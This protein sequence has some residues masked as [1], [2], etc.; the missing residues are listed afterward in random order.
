MRACCFQLKGLWVIAGVQRPIERDNE[1]RTRDSIVFL[2]LRRRQEENLLD[3]DLE[4]ATR[5]MKQA[6]ALS[7]A[8]RAGQ[9]VL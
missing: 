8:G 1:H 6:A 2:S 9:L 3:L 7:A 4:A 5:A